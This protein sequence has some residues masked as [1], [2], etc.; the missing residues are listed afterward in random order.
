MLQPSYSTPLLAINAV[1]LDTETTGLDARA[2]RIVQIADTEAGVPL[3][4]RIVPARLSK[5]QKA[6]LKEALSAAGEAVGLVAEGRL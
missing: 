4:A 3:S 2:A 6:E 1:V 5:P